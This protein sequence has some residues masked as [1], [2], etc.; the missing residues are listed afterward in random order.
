MAMDEA[1]CVAGIE[2]PALYQTDWPWYNPP[3]DETASLAASSVENNQTETNFRQLLD[4]STRQGFGAAVD[5]EVT[6]P[7][8]YST[9][10]VVNALNYLLAVHAQHPAYLRVTGKPVISPVAGLLQRATST[11]K[12]YSGLVAGGLALVL[13]LVA[14]LRGRRR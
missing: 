8:L 9:A 11:M 2:R 13:T 1:V 4:I 3:R 7:F 12:T 10:D 6:S 5:L 14:V